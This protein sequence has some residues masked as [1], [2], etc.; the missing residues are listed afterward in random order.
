MRK[1]NPVV[2]DDKNEQWGLYRY[3]DIEKILR[4]PLKFSSKF[5][6][7][8]VI[9]EFQKKLN[10]PSLLNSDPPYHRKLRSIV[11]I[12]FVP[13]EI[14]KLGPRIE[15]IANELSTTLLKMV[16]LQRI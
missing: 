9:Q 8:L 1:N 3:S 16:I 15:D 6:P 11:D 5:G 7:F 14:S 10:R 13:V 4:N 2:Y 12:L